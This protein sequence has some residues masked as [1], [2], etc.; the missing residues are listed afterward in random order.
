MSLTTFEP[1]TS[2]PPRTRFLSSQPR[3]TSSRAAIGDL[4]EAERAKVQP[5]IDEIKSTLGAVKLSDLDDLGSTV[6]SITKDVNQA[7]DAMGEK[8][9]L[10]CP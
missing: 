10:D 5:Q 6:D 8:D 3:S 7:L 4:T 2:T 9:A 1:G